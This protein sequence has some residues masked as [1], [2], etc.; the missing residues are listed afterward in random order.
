MSPSSVG[1]RG[2]ETPTAHN[3]EFAP[4]AKRFEVGTTTPAAHVGLVEGID[5][6]ESIGL[7]TIESRIETLTDRLKDGVAEERLLSPRAYESG[8]VSFDVAEPE[9]TVERLRERGIVIRDI[10]A[11]GVVRV[12]VHAIST[13]REVDAVVGALDEGP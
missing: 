4:G 12:L 9:A 11:A 7:D 13:E 6:V 5:A 8:L 2:V 3:I 10:P 1:Y